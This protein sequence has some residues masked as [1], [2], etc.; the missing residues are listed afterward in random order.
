M[1]GT[2]RFNISL[3]FSSHGR[4]VFVSHSSLDKPV[5]KDVADF[6]IHSRLDVYFDEYDSCLSGATSD[7]A[8]VNCIHQGLN[9]STHALCILSNNSLKSNWVPYEVGYST[10]RKAPLALLVLSEVSSIPEFYKLATVIPDMRGLREY[11]RQL[12]GSQLLEKSESFSLA[13]TRI[14]KVVSSARTMSYH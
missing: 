8:V 1:P 11:V 2:N 5:A 7:K 12:M 14:A 9:G 6:L 10:A 13:D 3:N 4:C